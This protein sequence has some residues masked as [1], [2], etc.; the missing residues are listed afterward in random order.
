MIL[1]QWRHINHANCAPAGISQPYISSNLV[2]DKKLQ[3]ENRQQTEGKLLENFEV[4][5]AKLWSN[6]KE[7]L[8]RLWRSSRLFKKVTV[9]EKLR[10]KLKFLQKF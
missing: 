7:I 10:R 8:V 3:V 6:F 9:S 1:L 5:L 2:P 4:T